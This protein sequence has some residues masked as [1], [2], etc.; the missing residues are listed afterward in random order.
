M[1]SNKTC[2]FITIIACLSIPLFFTSIQGR[3]SNSMIIAD[4]K[5][6]VSNE[7]QN[8]TPDTSRKH[9]ALTDTSWSKAAESMSTTKPLES[10]KVKQHGDTLKNKPGR[11]GKF[12]DP[13][14]PQVMLDGLK[15]AQ[16]GDL[17]GAIED[18]DSA[19]RKNPRN[20]N[21]YFYRAK[22][23]IEYGDK[24]GAMED[25]DLAIK[26]KG[27]EAIYYYYRG[28][29]L[30]DAG[31]TGKAL[32]DFDMAIRLKRNFTDAL[33]YRGVER[34]K[35]GM[36]K[37]AIQ[38]YD[39]AII[40]NPS[41]TLGYYNKGTSQAALGDFNAAM[42]SFS[43]SIQLD[44]THVL[45]YLNRGNC[46]VQLKEYNL[47]IADFTSAIGLDPGNSDAYFNRGAAHFLSGDN[48]MC[49]DWQ[50]AATLRNDKARSYLEK[51][52]K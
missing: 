5:V 16:A 3:P 43:K 4:G 22:A 12:I 8:H 37:E 15:K 39:S 46:Y 49:P 34:A 45:S 14:R 29:M 7:R 51:Y 38:D 32:V 44:T 19:I 42:L 31:Q 25:I 35:L 40:S 28:K 23:K 26:N 1:I 18:F 11:P 33:N 13:Y 17:K 6:I 20:F 10:A 2:S 9:Q 47:A 36:H 50:K 27:D 41:Y 30:S 52:C 21:A 48:L 24:T